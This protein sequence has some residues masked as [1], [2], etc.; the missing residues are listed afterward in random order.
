MFREHLT[1]KSTR[2][3]GDD[4]CGVSL[5][6]RFN[7]HLI[8]IW[9]RDASNQASINAIRAKVLE[10]LPEEFR[11]SAANIYYKKHSE[12][13]GFNEAVAAKKSKVENAPL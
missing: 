12:H 2:H 7:S 10:Q 13:N 4:I 9:N 1:D 6:V 3:I 8:S 5:S 11:P